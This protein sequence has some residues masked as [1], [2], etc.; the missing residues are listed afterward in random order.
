[1]HL[2]CNEKHEML[3]NLIIHQMSH[4]ERNYLLHYHVADKH[5][6]ID[7]IMGLVLVVLSVIVTAS[8]G[9]SLSGSGMLNRFVVTLIGLLSLSVSV[10]TSVIVFLN[11]KEKSI[12]HSRAAEN[13]YYLQTKIKNFIGSPIISEMSDDEIIRVQHDFVEEV[14]RLHLDSPA[15]PGWAYKKVSRLMDS[16]ESLSDKIKERQAKWL[17]KWIESSKTSQSVEPAIKK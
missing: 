3:V 4:A 10:L 8:I 14:R 16:Y 5:E 17:A 15:I 7:R 1:M 13:Y 2:P 6:K 11:N 9:F 12:S